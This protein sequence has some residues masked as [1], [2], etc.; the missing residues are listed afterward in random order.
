MKKNYPSFHST[1]NH[2]TSNTISQINNKSLKGYLKARTKQ[3]VLFVVLLFGVVGGA[4]GQV[5]VTATAGTVGPTSYTTV[6][7]AFTAINAGTHQGAITIRI[8]ANT[9]EPAAV[10]LLKSAAPSSYTSIS[11]MPVGN[12]TVTVP[13]ATNDAIIYLRGAD[14]VTID[15]DDPATAGAR[16]L[17]ITSPTSASKTQAIVRFSSNSTTGLDGADNNTIK[18]CIIIGSRS[19][20]TSTQTNY[21]IV[22]AN[23]ASNSTGAYSSINTRIENNLITRCWHGIYA[24]GVSA[25][26]PNTGTQ[27]LNNTLGSSVS[28]DNIGFRGIYLAYTAVSSGGALV[29][30]ND[31][32]VGDYTVGSGGY[33]GKIAAIEVNTVN[34]G[35][36]ID[37]NNIHDLNNPN[38]GYFSAIG[39]Y[40]TGSASNTNSTISNNYIRDLKVLTYTTTTSVPT[41]YAAGVS[42]V[43][44]A[45]GINFIHN[46]IVMNQQLSTNNTYVSYGVISTVSG[47]T[48]AKFQNN[49]IVNNHSSS[50]ATGFYTFATGNISGAS[51]NNNNYFVPSGLVGY[52]NAAARTTLANWQTA[53]SKDANAINVNPPFMSATDLHLSSAGTGVLSFFATGATGT[54]VSVDYD[55]ETRAATPCIGADEISLIAQ[56]ASYTSPSDAATGQSQTG[57]TLTW[58]AATYATGYDVFFDQNPSPTTQVATNQAGLTYST[59]VLTASTTYY[60][61]VVPKNSGGS[62][63]GCLTWSF[64]TSA[65]VPTLSTTPTSVS[66]GN[67]C[68]NSTSSAVSFN[69]NGLNLTGSSVTITA[70]SGFTISEDNITFTSSI[71]VNHTAGSFTNKAIYVKFSPTASGAASGNVVISGAGLSADVNVA[72]TG[73]G[74]N[75]AATATTGA[76]SNVLG[77]T[78]TAAG[79]YVANCQTIT[80]YGIEYSLTNGFANG[81]GT[82]VASTNQASGSFT[83]AL[84]GLSQ[85]TTYYY[86]SYVTY[87][88]TTVYGTQSSFTTTIT[89]A[90]IPYTNNFGSNDF[91]FINGAQ[92]NKWF[93][94]SATG[95]AA[96]SIYVSSNTG[97]SNTYNNGSTSVVQAYRDIVIPAGTTLAQFSFDW[98]A[99]GESG[100][101]YLRVWLVPSTFTPIAGT[102]TTAGSGR[103]QVG[104][105]LNLFTAW[106]T[107]TNA[108]LNIS[109]F[110]NSTMRL[111]FE[112]RNDGSGGSDTPAAVDNINITIPACPSLP[113]ALTSTNIST[114][115]ATISWTAASP[116]PGSGYNYYVSSTNTAPSASATP[117]GSVGAGITTASLTGLSANTT[118]YYWVRSNC[119]G[120]DFGAW[121]AGASFYTGYCTPT[122]AYYSSSSYISNLTTTNGIT[123]ISNLTNAMSSGGYGNFSSSNSCSAYPGNNVSITTN[124]TYGGYYYLWIDWNNDL[125]FVDPGESIYSIT[126]YTYS[127]YIGSI[128]VSSSQ[129]PG[130]YRIRVG[131]DNYYLLSNPCTSIAYYGEY[132]D[133]TLTVLALVPPTITNVP[134]SSICG[135]DQSVVITG[136]NFLG[137]TA[138]SINGSAVQSYTINTATQITAITSALNTSGTVSVAT[139]GGTGTSA[140]TVAIYALP[141]ITTQ[142]TTPASICGG[143]GTSTTSIL[144]SNAVSYQWYKNGVAISGAPYSTFTTSTLTITNPTVSENNASLTCVITGTG[145]CTVTSSAVYLTV[146]DAP[147]APAAFN[148]T[149][150]A[151]ET[152]NLVATS[153]GNGINWYAAATGGSPLNPSLLLSGTN[154]SVSPAVNTT[155]YAETVS[156]TTGS[157]TFN[158]TGSDQT[159]TV[160]AGVTSIDVKLWG[161]G[162]ASNTT[163]ATA[164][165]GAFIKGTMAVTPGQQLILIV[166]QGGTPGTSTTYGGGGSGGPASTNAGGSGGG[167]SALQNSSGSEL[168]TAAGGGGGGG[169]ISSNY[170]GGGGYTNGLPGSSNSYGATSGGGGGT[171]TAGG[172][173]GLGTGTNGNAGAAFTGGNASATSTTSG[174]GGGGGGYF[175]GG[176]GGNGVT[177]A[178][179]GGGGSSFASG[180]F[181]SVNGASGTSGANSACGAGGGVAGGATDINYISGIG[182]GANSCSINSG[183]NGLV[184][185][186][187]I[188]IGCA[189]DTRTPALVTI[190]PAPTATAGAVLSSICGGQTSAAMGGSVTSPATGGT[191][192]GGTGTWTD[193]SDP[194]NA[195]YTA[196]SGESG[197][198]TLTLTTTGGTCTPVTTTKSIVVNA[199]PV[200]NAGLD[201]S[202][203]NGSSTN[204]AA[205]TNL[206]GTATA[207]YSVGNGS[208]LYNGAPTTSTVSSCPIPLSVTIPMGA[209]I[210]GVSV[211]YTMTSANS[212]WMSEQRTYLKCT[213]A[214]GS[215]E[216]SVTSGVGANI[217]TYVYPARSNLTIAN[218]VIGG[219]VVNF[220]LHA[221][222]TFTG[223]G[224]AST[225]NYVNNNSFI[226][227]VTY[228]MPTT[229]SWTPSTALSATNISNPVANPTSTQTYLVTASLNGCTSAS[230]NVIVTVN[231]TPSMTSSSTATICSGNAVS[232]PLTSS[233][234]SSYSWIAT[235][236]ANTTGESTTAQTSSTLS[237]TITNST[238]TA[239]NV[240]YTVT[241]TSTTGTCV[242]AAQ[243]I[244]VTVNPKPTISNTASTIC[245]GGTFT[246]APV[247]GASVIVP[248]GTTYSWSAPSVSGITGT[249]SGSGAASIT[250]TL[251]NTTNSTINVAYTVTPIS[252]SGTCSGNTFTVTVTVRPTANATISGTTAVCQ[253]ATAPS[254]TFTNPTNV[255]IT[256]TYNVNGGTNTTVNVAA[257]ATTNVTVPTTTAAGYTYNLV[258]AVYQSAPTCSATLSGSATVTVNPLPTA[259]TLTGSTVCNGVTTSITS[260]TSQIGVN[261]QLY[262]SGNTVIGSAIAGTGSGLSW[263]G[264]AAGTGYYVIGTNATTS[265]NSTSNLVS[266]IVNAIP[267][268]SAGPDKTICIGNEVVLSG[269]GASG[270]TWDNTVT[271]G[272]PFIPTVTATYTVIGTDG[273]GCTNTDQVVLTLP[274]AGTALAQNDENATCLVSENGW[275]DFY[276]LTTGNL[277]GSINSLG[278]DLG[279]VTI[280]S[281]VD[282]TNALIPACINPTPST[283]T[284]VMQRHWVITP[285]IQ[286]TSNVL[287]R[288]PYSTTE[289]NLLAFEAFNN[290]N[291]NDD[292]PTEASIG[293]SKYSN[294]SAS[295]VNSSAL[296]NCGVGSSTYHTQTSNGLTSTYSSVDEKYVAF[297]IP[298][299]SEFWLHGSATSSPLPVELISFQAN[300]AGDKQVEVTWSTASEHNTSHFVVE[301][302]RDG[303]SWAT[304]NTLGAAGNS[305]TIIDYAL[306]DTDVANGTTY[307]RLTQFDLDGASETFNIASANCGEQAATSNLVTYPNPSNG[308]FYL[309]FY[310]Q[311]LTGPSSISVFD[312]RGVIIYRQ[313]V[314]VEKGSNVFHIEKMEAAPG[315]YYIQVSNG[316]TTS[317]I[318]KHSLR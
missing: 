67:V 274:T 150:C 82:Q 65:A 273:N 39:I 138:V 241:P 188:Q 92:T 298:G 225:Y 202:I 318:V 134:S 94:G 120:T 271:N 4:W 236:N 173:V 84:T 212:G 281:Y 56:C 43:A 158:Y 295:N 54:G 240:I 22:M 122:G 26:Y 214:G 28:A 116:A 238:N 244:T 166:G 180:I 216:A 104:G 256:V 143:S 219:G 234:P 110:A 59:G 275:I 63:T 276:N 303:V 78:A 47:V 259:L 37:G 155:Y 280:T 136:T 32:R 88:V 289:F 160:P 171:L 261:Y 97:T 105:D 230:D 96:N 141:T 199:M 282:P 237:N 314:L 235:N 213:N 129:A 285:T 224:C 290:S 222:Q 209:T 268:V 228:T 77:T 201:V 135:S 46:T 170:G 265:C 40:F 307:Y 296:D 175:G 75:T 53:T 66:A 308:S 205:S 226:V 80:S 223:T 51:V 60:W 25:T 7:A 64:T 83:S 263:N 207:T 101:D 99:N 98:K 95:N 177:S 87:G 218:G 149:I 210:T 27:I 169:G 142:P 131:Y 279:N 90:T 124:T 270:Y 299:F 49:I 132:E 192:T 231:P 42:F 191:W 41:D 220:E 2:F 152:A 69:M 16:N 113:T 24:N 74:I 133:Y 151:G 50:G 115:S 1:E 310:T 187:Y 165:G 130:N 181:S 17:T 221:F 208:T 242:G 294:G 178:S 106:Q 114:T 13:A 57:V 211:N 103:I 86:V 3:L 68:V 45:T 147:A 126:S 108:A 255:A 44:G 20:A 313:D 9:T 251:T 93:Y 284:T 148:A 70:P 288:L 286:P 302:S 89:P 119:N 309:D 62:A 297:T 291:L 161:A 195:T 200:V 239:Q 233:T 61:K 266:I 227:T 71:T 300:C 159:W 145:G 197:T 312:S 258:S 121:V 31:I 311:D 85:N 38:T 253:N 111:V 21:G 264:M 163:A 316:T 168:M 19:S 55:N 144:V 35:I 34:F 246:Y 174:G 139:A 36:T 198:I 176:G 118:Y 260:S 252:P 277:V 153:V 179:G 185:I 10:G 306:T 48:F 146:G 72:T 30:G 79:S 100:W 162:A 76:S 189:S 206:S 6:N 248:A 15:G 190:N 193:A 91:L 117:T 157:Q 215:T 232:I 304:L 278:Q 245:S 23:L 287:I 229:Y 14:N 112:W 317:Y 243:T 182:Q 167:R 254:V 283:S 172:T 58:S 137:T 267:N 269:S 262:N 125:D 156:T 257:N 196:L 107:Y 272:S 5:S 123:N 102:Q 183:G 81:A 73:A 293:L 250:G 128:S 29:K 301:K 217:G 305:T 194:F 186:S 8:T 164:G 184:Y 249:A 109:S 203:C 12:V 11:I 140:G 154:Y 52:Y 33:A 204:L 18:N 292:L 127:P 247:N 315:M